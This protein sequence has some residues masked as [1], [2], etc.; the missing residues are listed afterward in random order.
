VRSF[1]LCFISRTRFGTD[2][3]ST[4][5]PLDMAPKAKAKA[6]AKARAGS[7][8]TPA[9][10]PRSS[11]AESSSA[12]PAG[13]EEVALKA[14]ESKVFSK[15]N[16]EYPLD[17]LQGRWL[18]SFNGLM[19]VQYHTVCHDGVKHEKQLTCTKDGKWRWW[20][21]ELVRINDTTKELFWRKRPTV[22]AGKAKTVGRPVGGGGHQ[23]TQERVASAGVASS[24]VQAQQAAK[25]TGA[26][27]PHVVW[28][29][30]IP[31]KKTPLVLERGTFANWRQIAQQS[32]NY[33]GTVY[34]E[35]PSKKFDKNMCPVRVINTRSRT[36]KNQEAQNALVE[37][38]HRTQAAR[39]HHVIMQHNY[40]QKVTEQ[41]VAPTAGPREVVGRAAED[42]VDAQSDDQNDEGII[43]REEGAE[44]DRDDGEPDAKRR[45]ISSSTKSVPPESGAPAEDSSVGARG[46]HGAGDE[47]NK[48]SSSSIARAAQTSES[49][50]QRDQSRAGSGGEAGAASTADAEH[51][52]KAA[53]TLCY[54]FVTGGLVPLRNG[55]AYYAETDA[56]RERVRLVRET[57]GD[58]KGAAFA[59]EFCSS[60]CSAASSSS[61]RP[62][63]KKPVMK[64]PM[65]GV[66][67]APAPATVADA[68][69][70]A[71]KNA[72]GEPGDAAS[73]PRT[74]DDI[75]FFN[76]FIAHSAAAVHSR[77]ALPTGLSDGNEAVLAAAAPGPGAAE[78]TKKTAMT[79]MKGFAA[80]AK[81]SRKASTASSSAPDLPPALDLKGVTEKISAVAHRLETNPRNDPHTVKS[82]FRACNVLCSV[83]VPEMVF[84]HGGGANN[85]TRFLGG[86]PRAVL[87]HP[88][89]I[90]QQAAAMQLQHMQQEIKVSA[91]ASI[92]DVLNCRKFTQEQLRQLQ[93]QSHAQQ[94]KNC[95]AILQNTFAT[96]DLLD[97]EYELCA[98]RYA[99]SDQVVACCTLQCTKEKRVI[100]F[101]TVKQTYRSGG[102]SARFVQ[103]LLSSAPPNGRLFT[104]VSVGADGKEEKLAKFWRSQ[105]F[106]IEG[107]PDAP[108]TPFKNCIILEFDKA[109]L[110]QITGEGAA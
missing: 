83:P 8:Q 58:A 38:L 86:G 91:A 85:M 57:R 14:E 26:E 98:L 78:Q 11:V 41:S 65:R 71:P 93:R 47:K 106:T 6:K 96:E 79:S 64:G 90:N 63:T 12:V 30:L 89:K 95:H 32:S 45:K 5:R 107:V 103:M 100:L 99:H 105:G 61:A 68:S 50:P 82:S 16:P 109:R 52:S 60:A 74:A 104:V 18:T 69:S 55:L 9:Q 59:A 72:A 13:S 110:M 15:E 44:G 51:A 17:K 46:A 33:H 43:L 23:H 49:S 39:R 80:K 56:D 48:S 1:S 29:P 70:S 4:R 77:P 108:E 31:H 20:G 67:K 22:F 97:D 84:P 25:T 101:F 27:Q 62:T 42:V 102:L 36:R 88:L 2:G 53:P 94:F 92:H 73:P 19:S 87:Q 40:E 54:D 10:T 66:K 3:N 75:T 28:S 24:T 35:P 21:W 34:V 7:K 76:P 81:A 37:N